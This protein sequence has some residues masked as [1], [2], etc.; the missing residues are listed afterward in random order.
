VKQPPYRSIYLTLLALF[1]LPLIVSAQQPT[2]PPAQQATAD[3]AAA[4]SQQIAVPNTQAIS[5]TGLLPVYGVDL[6]L[7]PS[8]VDA[9]QF[10]S[11]SAAFPNSGTS[12]TFQQ[13]WSA[14]QAGGYNVLR[15]PVDVRDTTASANRAANLCV[16]AK[17]NNVQ[18][19]FAMTGADPGKP[20]PAE[21]PTKASDF[22][23]ALVALIRANNGQYLGNYSQIMALQIEHEANHPGKHGGMKEADAQKLLLA[24]AHSVRSAETD[25]LNG[26]GL[27]ATPLTTSVSFDFDLVSA[28]AI[29][30]GTLTDTAYSQAYQALKQFLTGLASSAD[31]DLLVVDWYPGSVGG[32][33]VEKVPEFLKSLLADVPGKQLVL[34]TGYS[35]AFRSPDEQ[36]RL[37]TT[38][39][40]NLSD[41]RASNGTGC[42]FAGVIFREALNGKNP[43]PN[44]PRATLPGD[45]DKW[46]WTAKAAE[47]TAIWTQRKKSEDMSWWL[48]KVENNMGLVTLQTDGSGNVA[49]SP[50]PAQQGMTQI[51]SAVSDANSQIAATPA[52][53]PN[54]NG[55]V[56]ST[57]AASTATSDP[58]ANAYAQQTAQ[59]PQPTAQV[60][61]TP[62][63]AYGA[64]ASN[65]F[66]Q[67]QPVAANPY[68][69][70]SSGST[71]PGCSP[72]YPGQQ[73]STDPNAPQ[74]YGQVSTPGC[75]TAAPVSG[76]AQGFQAF[77]QQ[78][79]M[80]L[81]NNVL[82]RLAGMA[83]GA[84]KSGFNSANASTYNNSY[85]NPN[86]YNAGV[87]STTDPNNP[88]SA[89]NNSSTYNNSNPYNTPVSSNTSTPTTTNPTDPGN[90]AN[91]YA[92]PSSPATS[93][94]TPQVSG[95]YPATPGTSGAMPPVAVQIGSQD[96][97]IQP[98]SLQVGASATI[99]V[100]LHNQG[101]ADASGLIVQA[102]GS[103]GATLAQQ[104]N[105]HVAPNSSAPVQLPWSPS[106][107]SPS[108]GITVSVSDGSGNILASAQSSPVSVSAPA[109]TNNTNNASNNPSTVGTSTGT[110]STN[111][112]A[113]NVTSSGSGATGTGTSTGTGS[114]DQSG[115]NAT[116]TG[117]GNTGGATVSGGTGGTTATVSNSACGT[118][119]PATTLGVPTA[120]SARLNNCNPNG[121]GTIKT[122]NPLGSVKL[123][124][125]QVGIPGQKVAAGQPATVVVP[126]LN[127]YMVPISSIQATLLIDGQSTQT[128]TLDIVLPQQSRSIVF[129][130][131][132]FAQSGTHQIAVNVVNQ[133]PGA[134]ALTSTTTRSVNIIDASSA[135]AGNNT[136]AGNTTA[137][138]TTAGNT[139]AGNG[140][141]NTAG[142]ATAQSAN[143]ASPSDSTNSGTTGTSAG[144]SSTGATGS[145][146][147]STDTGS[148]MPSSANA[149]GTGTS[150]A[151]S[152]GTP[153][154]S[155]ATNGT[156]SGTSST[157]VT[158]NGFVSGNTT[159]AGPTVRSFMPNTFVIGRA[160]V[161]SGVTPVTNSNPPATV[162]SVNAQ[163]AAASPQSASVAT[164]SSDS[165]NTSQPSKTMK[166]KGRGGLPLNTASSSG[167]VTPAQT[168]NGN[169]ASSGA[170]GTT[171]PAQNAKADN[172]TPMT[173][174]ATPAQPASS[175]TAPTAAAAVM[176]TQGS[177]SNAAPNSATATP[178]QA[179]NVANAAPN[180][181][182]ARPPA[183][184]SNSGASSAVVAPA[185][186]ATAGSSAP[187]IAPGTNS[188]SVP[189]RASSAPVRSIGAGGTATTPPN[190]PPTVSPA[191]TPGASSSSANAAPSA[192]SVLPNS[193]Q[194]ATPSTTTTSTISPAV[195]TIGATGGAAAPPPNTAVTVRPGSGAPVNTPPN[196]PPGVGSTA[197]I[198][199]AAGG[200]PPVQ[201]SAGLV[202]PGPN[203]ATVQSTPSNS[204]ALSRPG[205]GG[206]TTV[207]PGS[208]AVSRPG[209]PGAST[210]ITPSANALNRPGPAGSTATPPS[211]TTVLPGRP[212]AGAPVTGAPVTNPQG[213]V[214]L[215]VVTSEM[216]INPVAPRAGQMAAF[217]ALVRNLGTANVQGAVVMFNLFVN[218]VQVGASQPMAF[219]IAGHGTF[220]ANW[221]AV[222]PAGQQGQV[223]VTVNA[224]GDVN[225]ANNRA[226]LAFATAR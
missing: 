96:I 170:A 37:F 108:Y 34:G 29:A 45:M 174:A 166:T 173:T 7:D 21:F 160:V 72:A 128:Q 212:T 74:S 129:S 141:G 19:I 103:D 2:A 76:L 217:A 161:P 57:T 110:G 202:R 180:P 162:G 61:G 136:T 90:A 207:V 122:S 26:S 205:P 43:N 226:A 130:G 171:A 88:A 186:T 48:T 62:V 147:N 118:N 198:T 13:I 83:S 51:A 80:G 138:N 36:K 144:N 107:A 152:S 69:A 27:S 158:G 117:S 139:A 10:P 211:S 220:Q 16:W 67:P 199:P 149:G 164:P 116:S 100:N 78:G 60:P 127:P 99:S 131:I 214:D 44:P 24:A 39:F 85:A 119:V 216:R 184:V 189:G 8:W 113:G 52:S 157:P 191:S 14:L 153:A 201:P 133:R 193:K 185:Q 140:A 3:P 168:A 150:G 223:V 25:A 17:S 163:A 5:Q 32:G 177:G 47:L 23:K 49:A 200:A 98:S 64:V 210:T 56:P 151:A 204:N 101:P 172:A 132:T 187:T 89:L 209:T 6:R 114:T 81:L 97:S 28:G 142:N 148:T 82:Q 84:G 53:S 215:S 65:G 105:V 70:T 58:Y 143:G 109:N 77:A 104:T 11:Q 106:V 146:A 121:T 79:M 167:V 156:S 145:S 196:A 68:G 221:S 15:I 92:N 208:N 12:A 22:V 95:S 73:P 111:Q 31:L 86:P 175:N 59:Q 219:N 4:A 197:T 120:I 134:N 178:A 30:G 182:T 42:L 40:A 50:L 224:R 154:T 102:A 206:T 41:F 165:S 222:I 126:V 169:T 38:S 176:P 75:S 35:T 155:T 55:A 46:D 183:T 1:V 71:Q 125:I 137:G 181:V 18:L 123:S 66:N 192:T 87:P 188:A 194:G 190:T 195:R 213:T 63:D 218:G 179:P 94:V 9:S 124:M 159:V 112:G 91:N 93:G 225:L 203:G 135:A 115:G 20:I 33:G 54:A